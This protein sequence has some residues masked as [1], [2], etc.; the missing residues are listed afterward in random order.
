MSGGLTPWKIPALE[1]LTIIED[2]PQKWYLDLSVLDQF[3]VLLMLTRQQWWWDWIRFVHPCVHPSV[4]PVIIQSTYVDVSHVADTI[5]GLRVCLIFFISHHAKC[6]GR[7]RN[8]LS[9][10]TENAEFFYDFSPWKLRSQKSNFVLFFSKCCFCWEA[11]QS[12]EWA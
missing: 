4:H 6:I 1:N 7:L 12:P 9:F 5:L 8:H 2:L 11:F 10:N 3:K